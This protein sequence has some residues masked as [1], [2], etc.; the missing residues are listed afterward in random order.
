MIKSIANILKSVIFELSTY[1]VAGALAGL[2]IYGVAS[3][4]SGFI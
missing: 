4:F 3:I 2:G 1:G